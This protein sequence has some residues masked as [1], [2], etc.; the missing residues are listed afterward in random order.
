MEASRRRLSGPSVAGED[1]VDVPRK[2]VAAPAL[3]AAWRRWRL[4]SASQLLATG[5]A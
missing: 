2:G 4:R 3:R 5:P 1:E